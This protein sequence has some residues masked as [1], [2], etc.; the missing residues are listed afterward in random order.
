MSE[1][2]VNIVDTSP[3]ATHA[4]QDTGNTSLASLDGKTTV[5]NTGAVTVA[6][7][8]LPTG[9]ATS[10]AQTTGNASLSSIDGKVTA[11]NTGAVT[12]ASSALPTGAATAALQ[13]GGL[14]SALVSDRLKV[15]G[16]G[17]T[18]PV[19]AASLPLPTGA[20]T[21]AKQDTGNT[22]AAT[23]ATQTTTTATNT[24]TIAGAV[25]SGAMVVKGGGTAGAAASA[26]VTVQGIASM[27]PVQIG[28]NSGSLTVDAPVGTPVFVR[29]SDGAA[30]VAPVTTAQIPASL[31]SLVSASA[32]CVVR[33]VPSIDKQ[34]TLATAGK[35]IKSGPGICYGLTSYFN[36]TGG[37]IFF[38]VFNSTTLPSAGDRPDYFS[39]SIA[40]GAKNSLGFGITALG[41]ACPTGIVF[42]ASSTQDTFTAIAS[43]AV[44]YALQYD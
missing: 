28:D 42:V 31:G 3:L 20:A 40:S 14:P 27:T 2:V 9:A 29:L 43:T 16:S 30:A 39:A 25:N 22:S 41:I 33:S 17:V 35:L 13:G 4:K 6:A 11:C 32:L 24:G 19:S 38:Q 37:A 36:N 12:V 23:T 26:V 34:T 18:Q 5:C 21:E 8:A 15:D 10:A 44:I 1:G 7:S